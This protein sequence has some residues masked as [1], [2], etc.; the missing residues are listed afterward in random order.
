LEKNLHD[1]LEKNKRKYEG[2]R[3][4]ESESSSRESLNGNKNSSK[5]QKV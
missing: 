2:F 4:R 3:S 5:V 1:F